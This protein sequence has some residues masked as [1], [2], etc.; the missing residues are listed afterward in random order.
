M[1]LKVLPDLKEVV[2]LDNTPLLYDVRENNAIEIELPEDK[3][4]YSAAFNIGN[5]TVRTAINDGLIPIPKQLRFESKV[6]IVIYRATNEGVTPIFCQPLQLWKIS[7]T[8]AFTYYLGAGIS[9]TD[10]RNELARLKI[11]MN[12]YME[13]IGNIKRDIVTIKGMLMAS[14]Q[15][16]AEFK[17]SY[18]E[19]IEKMNEAL[20]KLAELEERY[21]V[22]AV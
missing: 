5:E 22:L 18:N 8:E 4:A 20:E 19:N 9:T 12:A 15:D 6:Q 10:I 7:N 2:I 3:A 11:V 1:K 16:V 17:S 21:D 13:A 14:N